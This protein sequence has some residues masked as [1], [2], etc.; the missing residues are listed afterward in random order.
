MTAQTQAENWLGLP[1]HINTDGSRGA[2]YVDP[3]GSIL[4]AART[5]AAKAARISRA[6]REHAKRYLSFSGPQLRTGEYLG[7]ANRPGP[8]S[9]G[10]HMR[11]A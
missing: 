11:D 3:D 6:D 5:A 1:I 10:H 8:T 7:L 9:R 4:A 2:P